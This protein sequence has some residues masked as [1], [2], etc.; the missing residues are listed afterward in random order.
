MSE[1]VIVT[2]PATGDEIQEVTLDSNDQINEKINA[3]E[4]AFL[5]FKSTTAYHRADLLEKWHAKILENKERAS[6]IITT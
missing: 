5:S 4:Q 1:K 6:E 2:N 3:A